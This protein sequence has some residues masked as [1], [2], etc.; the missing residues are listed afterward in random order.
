MSWIWEKS[1]AWRA[2]VRRSRVDRRFFAAFAFACVALPWVAGSLTM[3]AS[4]AYENG[5]RDRVAAKSR[6]DA[7]AL[8]KV[9]SERLGQFLDEIKH[10]ED[11]DDRYKAALRGETLTGTPTSR[12]RGV[13]FEV[14]GN[15]AVVI[16]VHFSMKLIVVS[17]VD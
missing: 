12:M 8:A 9:N 17:V 7:K 6:P 3:A 15:T 1:P 2:A 10:K 4:S 16:N 5:R 11:T 14:I 13:I